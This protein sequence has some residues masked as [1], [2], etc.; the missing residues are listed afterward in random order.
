MDEIKYKMLLDTITEAKGNI[1]EVRSQQKDHAEKTQKIEVTL[2]KVCESIEHHIKRTDIL[3]GMVEPIH[4]KKV[5]ADAIKEYKKKQR[6]DLMYRL[7]LPVAV[8]AALGAIGYM[9]SLFMGK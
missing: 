8:V 7:K 2:S 1:Q 9:I 5:E 4:K 3:E 6:E